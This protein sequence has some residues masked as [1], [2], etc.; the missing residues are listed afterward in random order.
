MIGVYHDTL[1][2]VNRY[3]FEIQLCRFLMERFA[4]KT[5]DREENQKILPKKLHNTET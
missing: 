5:E 2:K 4:I 1:P 3:K